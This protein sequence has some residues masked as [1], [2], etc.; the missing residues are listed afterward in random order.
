MHHISTPL[1]LFLQFLILV[2]FLLH[3]QIKP[4]HYLS[5]IIHI[6]LIS[7]QAFTF[8]FNPANVLTCLQTIL[9]PSKCFCE[10]CYWFV[11]IFVL[12]CVLSSGSVF[13][14]CEQTTTPPHSRHHFSLHL[15]LCPPGSPPEQI[16][17][18]HRV[19]KFHST[20]GTLS[21][22]QPLVLSQTLIKLGTKRA[23]QGSPFQCLG[24]TPPK[25]LS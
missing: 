18:A 12:L 8:Y 16:W 24:S 9:R 1:S 14:Y 3:F 2:I 11:S 22:A 17:G 10:V 7:L 4:S 21:W 6:G 5:H 25:A 13:L 23:V 15:S 19:K 20:S